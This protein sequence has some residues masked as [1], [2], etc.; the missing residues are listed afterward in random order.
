MSSSFRSGPLARCWMWLSFI[1]PRPHISKPAFQIQLSVDSWVSH[2]RVISSAS[3][4]PINISWMT[5]EDKD[6]GLRK[7]IFANRY[8]FHV[9]HRITNLLL[10]LSSSSSPPSTPSKQIW[11][12]YD[13]AGLRASN[14]IY[15]VSFISS[16]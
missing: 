14:L 3:P 7:N 6:I 13:S 9:S 5:T 8:C 10:L 15:H 1:K 12:A 11:I 4:S 16:L 2:S